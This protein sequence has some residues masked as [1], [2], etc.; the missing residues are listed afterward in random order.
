MIF[1]NWPIEETEGA[2]LAYAITAGSHSFRKGTLLTRD[3]IK[4]LGQQRITHVFA[5]RL[6]EYDIGEDE[7]ALAIGKLLISDN[8]EPGKPV[9]GRINLFARHD[10]LFHADATAIDKINLLDSRISVATLRNDCRVN[11]GQMVA[12]VKII[13]F[14]VPAMLIESLHILQGGQNV[15]DVRSFKA[16][17]IG[18]IQSQLPTI[19][20]TVLDKTTELIAK[21]VERNHGSVIKECRVA[22]EQ[23]AIAKAIDELLSSCDVVLIFSAASI[24]DAAD[25]VPRSIVASGGEILRI[26]MPVDPGNL[27]VL[28]QCR[29]KP[30]VVAPGSARS[31][32]ENSLDWVLDRLMANMDL[33]A[34]DLGK[35]G[36]GG[37]LL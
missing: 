16:T 2:M 7:A 17:K 27:L 32:R 37:L 36:V 25:I 3:Q 34:N 10:G 18:M 21:R 24:A 5:A 9:T 13:P 29:T 26:G 23:D 12:T 1:G 33:T 4:I 15:L 22:H 8:I 6:E 31:A 14:A 35:M 19:R 30:I 28:A 20:D 11:G